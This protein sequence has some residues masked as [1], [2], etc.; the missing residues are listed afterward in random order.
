MAALTDAEGRKGARFD[1][2]DYLFLVN[3]GHLR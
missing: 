3:T 2:D 1:L